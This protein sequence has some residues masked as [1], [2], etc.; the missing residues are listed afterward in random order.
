[1]HPDTKTHRRSFLGGVIG[2]ACRLIPGYS[3]DWIK[4]PFYDNDAVSQTVSTIL[5]TGLCLYVWFGAQRK[6]GR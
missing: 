1:V 6:A 3:E 4:T 5:F 2:A